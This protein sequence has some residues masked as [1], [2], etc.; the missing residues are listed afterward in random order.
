MAFSILSF[1]IYAHLEMLSLIGCKCLT[2]KLSCWSMRIGGTNDEGVV[3]ELLLY[4]SNK[5]YM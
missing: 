2:D 4:L 3:T 1:L 5:R